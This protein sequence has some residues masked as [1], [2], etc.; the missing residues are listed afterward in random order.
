MMLL[1]SIRMAS[2]PRASLRASFT[3]SSYLSANRAKSGPKS[4]LAKANTTTDRR[5]KPSTPAPKDPKDR[6]ILPDPS[7]WRA[8]FSAVKAKN[9]ISVSNPHSAAMLADAF[10]PRGSKGKVII[11]AFPGES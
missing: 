9:R 1:R 5:R 6:I 4:D 8:I 11:E 3:S 7:E 2:L 10:V